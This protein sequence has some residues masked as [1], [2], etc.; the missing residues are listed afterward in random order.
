[1]YA[2]DPDP[3]LIKISTA[4]GT[5]KGWWGGDAGLFILDGIRLSS[6]FILPPAVGV[7]DW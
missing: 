5:I 1:M 2:G 6:P 7:S 4:T 3:D